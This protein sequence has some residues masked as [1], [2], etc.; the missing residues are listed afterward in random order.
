VVSTSEFDS[1][2]GRLMA[3]ENRHK[4]DDKDLN[5]PRLRK[6]AGSGTGTVD[7][8]SGKDKQGSD[9]DSN[10]DDRPTLKRRD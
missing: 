5:K 6:K 2:K 10:A 9:T 4:I 7:D 8:E 1:V 3:L